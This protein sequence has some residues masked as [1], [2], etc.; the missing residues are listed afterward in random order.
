MGKFYIVL[1]SSKPLISWTQVHEKS[2]IQFGV[3]D[4]SCRES[5]YNKVACQYELGAQPSAKNS[6]EGDKSFLFLLYLV[7][8]QPVDADW[9]ETVGSKTL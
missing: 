3:F 8:F 5:T 6:F 7:W 1:H 9:T 2:I 4:C